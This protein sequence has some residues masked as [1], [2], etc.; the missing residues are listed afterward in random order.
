V[1]RRCVQLF[2]SPTVIAAIPPG[3]RQPGGCEE[4]LTGFRWQA[5]RIADRVQVVRVH[6]RDRDA[7]KNAN[8]GL[9]K[10]GLAVSCS[11]AVFSANGDDLTTAGG[12]SY[13]DV[14]VLS[15]TSTDLL[16]QSREG[17]IQLALNDLKPGDRERFSKD[18]TK[19]IELPAVT[20]IGEEKVD[21]S[22]LPGQERGERF[23]E[24]EIQQHDAAAADAHKKKVESYQPA[25]LFK[26]VTFSLG[27]TDPKNDAAILPDYVSPEYNRQ[28]PDIVEKDL[29]VFSDALNNK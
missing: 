25:E 3:R 12:K 10:L 6:I 16:I 20:V 8:D 24:K 22:A 11:I 9:R 23:V 7:W 13:H 27:T 17:Q 28:S 19:A 5:D 15:R 21:L 18:L 1:K 14:Q 4:P 26:G 29:K 2:D